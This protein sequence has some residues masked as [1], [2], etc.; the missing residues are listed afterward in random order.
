[1]ADRK[2]DGDGRKR[3]NDTRASTKQIER[4]DLRYSSRRITTISN[5]TSEIR[6]EGRDLRYSSRRH[7]AETV[8]INYDG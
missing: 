2:K 7:S 3:A 4:R 8:I 5:Y 6:M 1:M